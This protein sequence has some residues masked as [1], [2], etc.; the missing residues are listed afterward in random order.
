MA[1]KQFLSAG[2]AAPGRSP[3]RLL[4]AALILTGLSM[5]TAVTSVGAVLD[6]LQAGLHA[7]SGVA[8]VITTLPVLCFA[9]LGALTPRLSHRFG[10]HRL[11]VVALVLM[12]LGLV[13]RAVVGSIWAFLLLSVLA[14]SGGAIS[15][16]LMPSLVKRHFPDHIG[17]M[18]AVYT[19]ALAIGLTASAGL[20]VPIGRLGDGWRLGLGSWA[21]LSAVAVLPWLPTLRR[22]R[23]D[24]E[25][26]RGMSANRLAHSRTAWLLMI[27]FA[28]QSFQ[29][30]IAFGWF[31]KFLHGHGLS[32]DASGW[33]VA[34]I[35]AVSI[36]VSMIVPSVA[37]K[38]HQLV[39]TVLSV[40]SLVAYVGLAV[41][42]VGG[43][44][45]WMVLTGIGGGT[46]P[47]ALT[48]IGLRA[49]TAETTAALSAFVQAIGYIVA[50]TGPVLF[51]VLYGATGRWALPFAVL[52][53]ALA[54]SFGS[55]WLA[56][57]ATFVDDELAEFAA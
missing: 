36:P 49:R 40:C 23:P 5:R 43:A 14:L 19:T 48:M 12:T 8:G 55:G 9:A 34:L 7:G 45:A 3:R 31:A 44:W 26:E 53:I 15:N 35:A 39:I 37:P 38:R 47:I 29:A 2:E 21:L 25:T 50:G 42:P 30:Y 16:V 54:I 51:G 32:S 10:A 57:R 56:C 6:D 24:P 17:R 1:H 28:F 13:L 22:D 41:A 20:T 11:L 46:F 4:L 33:L 27:F 52:F 18:T